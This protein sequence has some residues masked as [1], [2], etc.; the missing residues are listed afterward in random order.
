[1]QQGVSSW[2][3]HIKRQKRALRDPPSS[4]AAETHVVTAGGD[5]RELGSCSAT[6]CTGSAPDV[7]LQEAPG[8]E[9]V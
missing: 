4:G 9:E 5:G 6:E 2:A 1:M 3:V 8:G 7:T